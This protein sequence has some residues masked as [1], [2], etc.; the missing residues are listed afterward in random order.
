MAEPT[1]DSR[2]K[3]SLEELLRLK[4]AERPEQD[5]WKE[6]DSELHHRMMQTL[7]KKDPWTVQLMRGLSGKF[8]QTAVIA[9]AAGILALMVIRPAFNGSTDQSHPALTRVD[10]QQADISEETVEDP[11]RATMAD[12]DYGMEVVSTAGGEG[13]N[14]VTEDY[15]LDH[16]GVA[17]YDSGVY[18]ADMALSGFT[19]T[20]V[21]SLV[22]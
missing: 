21:A 2:K 11:S 10:V 7:V 6:F 13:E 3:V 20:A 9:G 22:Y 1:K 18:A 17:S 5:F 14:A 16:I 15:G 12:A 8:A 4:R 19:S